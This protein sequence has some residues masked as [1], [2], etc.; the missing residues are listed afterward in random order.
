MY[1]IIVRNERV[2]ILRRHCRQSGVRRRCPLVAQRTRGSHVCGK[3]FRGRPGTLGIGSRVRGPGPGPGNCTTGPIRG[4]SLP[5]SGPPSRSLRT[6]A[7]CAAAAAAPVEHVGRRCGATTT[8]AT[9]ASQRRGR[10]RRHHRIPVV[11]PNPC[12]HIQTHTRT[13]GGGS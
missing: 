8:T 5:P 11:K 2:L 9:A 12:A 6:G 1:Y 13:N 7:R 10:R 4:E 3:P